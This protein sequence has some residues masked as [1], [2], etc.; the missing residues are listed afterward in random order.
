[1]AEGGTDKKEQSQVRQPTPHQASDLEELACLVDML[2]TKVKK[3]GDTPEVDDLIEMVHQSAELL[4]PIGKLVLGERA[5]E[6]FLREFRRRLNYRER[7]YQGSSDVVWNATDY[8]VAEWV[9]NLKAWDN[10]AKLM[11]TGNNEERQPPQHEEMPPNY[12]PCVLIV[13]VTAGLRKRSDAIA[14]TLRA[15][16]YPIFKKANKNYCD[17]HHAAALFPAWRRYW[18]G[19]GEKVENIGNPMKGG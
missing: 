17:P 8:D 6:D 3:E 15:A 9:D 5:Y 7:S 18:K 2:H 10:S 11:V 1:M 14:R 4:R 13:Q 19:I 12:I 16:G